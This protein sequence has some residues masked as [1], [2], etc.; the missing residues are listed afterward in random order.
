MGTADN[1]DDQRFSYIAEELRML[2]LAHVEVPAVSNAKDLSRID[3]AI[4]DS[5]IF[6]S[7]CVIDS[8]CPEIRKGMKFNSL[9]ELQFFLADY[10]VHHHRPFYV[11]HSDKRVRYDVLC[12]QGCLWGV[13]AR[14]VSGTGQWKITN[15]KQPH[16]CASSKPKQV[17]AQCT[18]RYL[19]HRILGI[20]QKDS[21]TS[22]PSLMESIFALSSYRVKYSKAW[23]AKQH[24]I[25]LLWG[26]WLESYARVPRVLTGMSL[27]NPGIRWFT[28]M[29]NMMLPHNGVYKHVLQ[30]VFWCF[31][32]CAE[33]FQH[34]RPV[35]LVD[36]TF[37]TG[38][39][40]GGTNDGRC[41]GP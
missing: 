5:T 13:W 33:A 30:R 40:K 29:G 6:E 17:H 9:P 16:T 8:D 34:C 21:D 25:A 14:I 28:Y 27:F 36:A 41:R 10:A 26:D 37:L 39:Y 15:V 3:R 23:R 35:I 22:V 7:E 38:K 20:V 31:P 4:C 11:V 18:T 12:K 1:N 24:A 32:Q 19:D 2:K